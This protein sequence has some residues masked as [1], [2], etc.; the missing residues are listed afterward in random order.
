MSIR[1]NYILNLAGSVIPVGIS[2]ITIP[3]YLR[4]IGE[5]RYG[6][7][8]I[9]W[10]ILGY[11]GL[12]DI[13]LGRAAAQRIAALKNDMGNRREQAFWTALTMSCAMGIMASL[14]AWVAC[15]YSSVSI[16][17]Y[18]DITQNEIDVVL[19]YLIVALPMV[20]LSSVLVGALQ[21]QEAF[22]ELNAV[23]VFGSIIFQIL[24]II[25]ATFFGRDLRFV[26]PA[27]LFAKI[28]TMGLLFYFSKLRI[29]RG[30]KI[31]LNIDEAKKMIQFGG[32]VTVTSIIGPLMVALDRLI[33][34]T[35][36]G[37]KA[38]TYYT[39]PFQLAERSTLISNSLSSALFP[40]FTNLSKKDVV[41]LAVDAQKLLILI[42][43]PLIIL[44]IYMVN[45]FLEWWIGI[46]FSKNVG[47][48]GII[49][50]MGFW[51]NSLAIIPYSQLQGGG[52]PDLV[53]KC[54]MAELLP[55]CVF[56]Y[57]M[58]NAFGL[59]GAAIV[60]SIRALIDF[61]LLSY[62]TSTL[63]KSFKIISIPFLQIIL[64][65]TN[66]AGNQTLDIYWNQFAMLQLIVFVVWLYKSFPKT[67]IVKILKY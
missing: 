32:W 40:K 63:K 38:V 42:M 22:L 51:I 49:L 56:L 59:I 65:Y 24:P 34:G 43:T 37:A 18:T 41:A 48:V 5:S 8:T 66:S 33:I 47:D 2:L 6:I 1:N 9:F 36:W 39:I 64:A 21:G 7:L 60:F 29:V 31:E 55:Y 13:G 27:A 3:I 26:L 14:I 52:R 54:H 35:I 57:W 50:L 23:S 30:D 15:N 4:L 61:A 25:S 67:Y 12:F 62:F 28:T 20:T 16:F 53:A 10:L 17:K 19:I 46:D 11:M 58:L 44:G 45:P